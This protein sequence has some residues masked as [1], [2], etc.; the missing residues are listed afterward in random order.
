MN[1]KRSWNVVQTLK[2]NKSYRKKEQK[3][4]GEELIKEIIQE[5]FP[6]HEVMNLQIERAHGMTQNIKLKKTYI[7]ECN[8]EILKHQK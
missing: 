6:D 2:K 1:I 7:R 3:K 8:H 5:S 4:I